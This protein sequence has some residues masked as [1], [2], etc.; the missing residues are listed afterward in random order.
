MRSNP[1]F[2]GSMTRQQF[3][4]ELARNAVLLTNKPHA[5]KVKKAPVDIEAIRARKNALITSGVLKVAGT[6]TVP[7][8]TDRTKIV[9]GNE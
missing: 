6:T 4:T 1:W 5:G 3:E 9:S 8:D 2:W 7:N